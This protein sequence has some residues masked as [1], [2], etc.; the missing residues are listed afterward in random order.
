M[1]RWFFG[2]FVFPAALLLS[3]FAFHV[4]TSDKK[5]VEVSNL[6][7]PQYTLLTPFESPEVNAPGE[8]TLR[9]RFHDLPNIEEVDPNVLAMRLIDT[10]E[11]AESDDQPEYRKSEIIAKN[12]ERWLGLFE[13][14]GGLRFR[15]VDVGVSLHHRAVDPDNEDFYYFSSGWKKAPVFLIKD[16]HSLHPHLVTTLFHKSYGNAAI[17]GEVSRKELDVGYIEKFWLFD[18]EYVLRV[19][20]GATIDGTPVNVLVLESGGASQ[21]LTY[22]LYYHDST[23]LYNSVGELLFV[24]DLDGDRKL[25]LYLSDFGFEKGGFGSQLF[26]SSEAKNDQLV[27]LAAVFGTS[28]C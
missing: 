28:G 25:D 24:G 18:T 27:Q 3:L 17:D 6:V 8:S 15:N 22:N 14:R 2:F 1:K 4:I 26:I 16:S 13:E 19:V 10:M 20:A 5:E 21:V 9:P 12:K 23:T 11:F 7:V